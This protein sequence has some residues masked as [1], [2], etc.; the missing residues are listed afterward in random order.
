MKQK[1]LLIKDR[2]II[3]VCII[4]VRGETANILE[5][6]TLSNSCKKGV[7]IRGCIYMFVL[8]MW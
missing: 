6:G 2:I 5:I 3:S 7:C 4:F 8:Y 1:K